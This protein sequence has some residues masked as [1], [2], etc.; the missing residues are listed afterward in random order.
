MI[1]KATTDDAAAIAAI[2]NPFI[3]D[4]TVTFEET[5]LSAVEM[6][7][8]IA[9]IAATHPWLVDAEGSSIRG[10]AYASPWKARSA[11]RHCAE[12][13]IYLA[14]AAR[15]RGIGTAL[16]SALVEELRRR[17]FH[18]LLG[19]IAQPNEASVALHEKLGFRKVGQLLEVGWKFERRIDVGYWELLL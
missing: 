5:P 6:A 7:A 16:Y 11:Y 10:Y 2:Y 1:R 4:T 15:G 3:L 18:A 9:S 8:R 14:P 13:T 12:C 19:G 17:G